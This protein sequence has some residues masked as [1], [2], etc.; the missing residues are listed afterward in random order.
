MNLSPD[1][2]RWWD[3]LSLQEARDVAEWLVK[4]PCPLGWLEGEND[5]EQDISWAFTECS[6][7]LFTRRYGRVL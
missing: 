6:K 2:K 4:N 3:G 5:R 1:V 7:G